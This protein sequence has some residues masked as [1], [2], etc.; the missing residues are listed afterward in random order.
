MSEQASQT[1][2]IAAPPERVWAIVTE[3]ERYPEWAKDVKEA[4]V[5]ERDAEGHVR[6]AGVE[7]VTFD[8]VTIFPAMVA[9]A[10]SPDDQ[11]R[12]SAWF[13]VGNLGGSGLGG[14]L[15]I[16]DRKGLRHGS[17]HGTVLLRRGSGGR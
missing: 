13:Q 5:L 17:L 9:A 6:A 2:T 4:V 14:G 8:I 12:V 7:L 16:R 11:G 3:F 1:F 15:G 10:T